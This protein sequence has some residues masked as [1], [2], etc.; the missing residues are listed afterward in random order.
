MK[1]LKTH[2][3]LNESLDMIIEII[4]PETELESLII[5]DPDFV[6]GAL[7]GKPRNGHPEGQVI[8]HIAD[9]LRNIDSMPKSSSY[10]ESLRLI[11]IIHDTFKYKVDTTKP[12]YGENHHAMIARRFAE[13]YISDTKIL[14]V[15][16]L[17]DEAY[18]AYCK[19]YRRGQ[20][21][22]AEK[23]ANELIDRLKSSGSLSL[24]LFFYLSDNTTGD[25]DSKDFDWFDKL[26][27]SKK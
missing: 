9:V 4:K 15:I 13:K 19:G 25:K 8:Y 26:V 12:K 24:F 17:H 18:N 22:G 27:F 5:Q 2:K 21:Y 3:Q 20:W 11:A 7:W 10:R 1:Y 14:D 6:A 16:E 23:R